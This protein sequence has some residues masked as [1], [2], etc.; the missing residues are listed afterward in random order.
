MLG[1][2]YDYLTQW[3]NWTGSD[4]LLSLLFEQLL[5]TITALAI[6]MLLLAAVYFAFTVLV[7]QTQAAREVVSESEE[8]RGLFGKLNDDISSQLAGLDPRGVKLP[9]SFFDSATSSPDSSASGSD[10]S[11]S[12]ASPCASRCCTSWAVTS[13]TVSFWP[14]NR[15]MRSSPSN[16]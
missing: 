12:N 14:K 6:A 4:G 5:L 13:A 3:S 1:D 10:T 9:D 8:V 11:S 15:C 7:S 16:M 2:A